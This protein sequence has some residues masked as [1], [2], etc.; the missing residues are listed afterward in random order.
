MARYERLGA[1]YFEVVTNFDGKGKISFYEIN[2]HI[3]ESLK[4]STKSEH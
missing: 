2:D 1:A 4:Q 3:N